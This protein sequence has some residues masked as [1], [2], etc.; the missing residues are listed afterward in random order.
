[1]AMDLKKPGRLFITPS[2]DPFRLII[3]DNSI[4]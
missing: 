3:D 2:D 4:V 1:M